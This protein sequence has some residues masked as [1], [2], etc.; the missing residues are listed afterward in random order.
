MIEN[1]LI[2]IIELLFTALVAV[3]ILAF[4]LI[5]VLTIA[6]SKQQ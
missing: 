1:Y 3:A 5:I 2:T 6:L 4:A